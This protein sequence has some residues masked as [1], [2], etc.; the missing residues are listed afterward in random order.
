GIAQ[1]LDLNPIKLFEIEQLA[2]QLAGGLGNHHCIWSSEALE[3][4]RE[5]GGIADH[6]AFLRRPGPDQIAYDDEAG[7]NPDPCLQFFTADRRCAD[8]VDD[9]ECG[10]HSSLDGILARGR[11]AEID[12]YAIPHVARYIAAKTA[13]NVGG[14]SEERN[15]DGTV[16][17]RIKPCG[18]LRRAN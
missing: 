2:E 16:I 12:E 15:H 6:C 8:R 7:G 1:A 18:E 4:S 13:N 5:I 17:L 10:A 9:C 14:V 11:P 3:S